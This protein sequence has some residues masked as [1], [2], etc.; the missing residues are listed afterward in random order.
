[1]KE[2]HFYYPYQELLH[3]YYMGLKFHSL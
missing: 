2:Y 1:M 3:K